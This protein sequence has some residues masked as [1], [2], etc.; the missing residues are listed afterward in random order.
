MFIK[1]TTKIPRL[2]AIGFI[3]TGSFIYCC[4]N[5]Y[6]LFLFGTIGSEKIC[7]NVEAE[8]ENP[9]VK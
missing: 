4:V 3:M 2:K 8:V 5:C 6:K 7:K 9:L 1:D